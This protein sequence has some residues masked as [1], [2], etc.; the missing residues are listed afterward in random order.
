[1]A[2]CSTESHEMTQPWPMVSP[3]GG[4]TRVEAGKSKN[5]SAAVPESESTAFAGLGQLP[6]T[7]SVGQKQPDRKR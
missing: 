2:R 1:V 7:A 6:T 3:P 4:A 5:E